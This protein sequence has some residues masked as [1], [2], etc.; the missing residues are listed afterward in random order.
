MDCYLI[1][2]L[3]DQVNR[4]NGSGHTFVAQAWNDMLKSF[5]TNFNSNLD[6]DV[7]KNRYKHLKK[8]YN[9]INTL[10]GE[11][12]FSWDNA[13]E[14]VTA[15]DHV[16]DTYIKAHPDARSYRVK[17][18]PNFHKL[19]VIYGQGSEGR[20]SHLARTVGVS[21]TGICVWFEIHDSFFFII[22]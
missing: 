1:D 8:Q 14:M 10:L 19:C 21:G 9:E 7:L 22:I 17:T 13:R 16:W 12:G 18:M 3:L 4:G 11:R 2:L 20:Y 15:K 5:N 6:K